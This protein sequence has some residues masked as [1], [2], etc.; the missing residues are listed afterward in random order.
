MT[1]TLT[2]KTIARGSLFQAEENELG[3]ATGKKEFDA[4][5]ELKT[6]SL[7]SQQEHGQSV[8]QK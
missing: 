8:I 1:F 5:E 3:R 7:R 2:F 6:Y 4:F